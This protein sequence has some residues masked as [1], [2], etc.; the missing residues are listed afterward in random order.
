MIASKLMPNFILFMI[1]LE[2]FE[3]KYNCVFYLNYACDT[4]NEN[5]Y[6]CTGCQCQSKLLCL[7]IPPIPILHSLQS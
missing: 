4:L 7:I 6:P 3:N 1:V 2:Q 5:C